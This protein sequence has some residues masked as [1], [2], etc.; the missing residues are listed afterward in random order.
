MARLKGDYSLTRMFLSKNNLDGILPLNSGVIST[1]TI[2]A[3]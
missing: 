1:N 2:K 3:F